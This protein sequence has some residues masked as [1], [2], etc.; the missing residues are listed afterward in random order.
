MQKKQL[1][2]SVELRAREHAANFCVWLEDLGDSWVVM[3]HNAGDM[4][5]YDVYVSWDL[6]D[7]VKWPGIYRKM[8]PVPEGEHTGL[9]GDCEFGNVGPT[10]EPR[11]E[12]GVGEW[13]REGAAYCVEVLEQR[14]HGL[15]FP[16]G[17]EKAFKNMHL[18]TIF[19]DVAGTRWER[20]GGQLQ[21]QEDWLA[22]EEDRMEAAE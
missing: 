13:I 8:R 14:D 18:T 15:L 19:T 11:C 2:E 3:V 22:L 5:V 17:L 10:S 16:P 20:R 1:N 7:P 6:D 12:D 21:R 9:I 4:P